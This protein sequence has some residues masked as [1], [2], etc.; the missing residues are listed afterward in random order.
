[1]FSVGGGDLERGSG[2]FSSFSLCFKG[3]D[4]IKGR[5]LFREK[6]CTPRENPGYAYLPISHSHRR[7]MHLSV[8]HT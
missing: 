5:Q 3:V 2:E 4:L 7:P 6:K 1:M 8:C